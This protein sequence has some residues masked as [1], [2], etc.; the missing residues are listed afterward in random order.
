MG[1]FIFCLIGRVVVRCCRF[2]LSRTGIYHL[3]DWRQ[4]LLQ[5]HD[6]DIRFLRLC[7]TRAS[8]CANLGDSPV[9]ESFAFG[10]VECFRA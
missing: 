9:S 6:A 2:E 1:H 10:L 3:E 4:A 5:A 8:F 7:P